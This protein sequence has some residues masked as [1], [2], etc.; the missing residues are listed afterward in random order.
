MSDVK[1]KIGDRARV[2]SDYD[3]LSLDRDKLIGSVGTV[4][5]N[6]PEAPEYLFFKADDSALDGWGPDGTWAVM[7]YELDKLES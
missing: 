4:I 2:N 3:P 1:F 7:D 5:Q 6:V